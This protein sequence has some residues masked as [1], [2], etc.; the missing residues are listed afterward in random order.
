MT[1]ARRLILLLCVPLAALLGL[2]VFARVQLARIEARSRFVAEQEIPSL[3]A[4]GNISRNFADLR[5]TL[6]D[7]ALATTDEQRRQIRTTFERD[8]AEVSRLLTMYADN[9]ISDDKDRRMCSEYRDLSREYIAR[10][11]QALALTEAGR[12]DDATALIA[13]EMKSLGERLNKAA[14]EWIRYNQ[15]IAEAAGK[16]AV[17]TIGDS[18]WKMMLANGSAVLLTAILGYL[19]FRRIVRPIQALEVSVKTIAAGDYAKQV[20]CTEAVDE[21]GGLARSINVL[22]QGAAAM[23]AQRW[24][25]SSAA[26]ITGDLQGAGSYAE[27][28]WRF[29]SGL[30]PLLG[31]GVGGFFVMGENC[32]QLRRLARYGLAEAEDAIIEVAV[33]EGLVGQCAHERKPVSLTNV[34]AGYLRIASGLGGAAPTRVVA[35]PL[36]SKDSLLGVVEFASF[37]S[38]NPQEQ[39]LLDELIPVVALSLEVLQRNLRTQELLTQTREQA[40]QLEEQTDELKQSQEELLAQ[41][42]ELLAQQNAL[43][44]QRE[45]LRTSEERT[46][47]ILESTAE[48]IFGVDTK[49]T[50]DF[51][52]EAACRLLGFSAGEMIGQ[53]SHALIH[54]HHPDGAVYPK[55]QCPMFAAYTRGEASRIDNEYLWRKDGA[56]LPV[57]YGATPIHKDRTI[58][59]AVISFTDITARKRAEAELAYRLAFQ[60]ALIETIP[61]PMFVKDSQARF[62]SCN[63]AYEREFGTTSAF[64]KDKTALELEYL[65]EAERRKFHA[66]DTAVIREAGRRSYELPIQYADGQTHITLYSVDG[67]RLNDGSPGGLIGLLVDIS[68]QK[69]VAEELREAKAKAEEATQMKSMFLAN[70]S[71]EIRTPMNAIIG[72][73]HLALKTPLNAKQRDY[74]SKVHNAGTSLL[75]VINDILDFSKIEAGK[76]DLETTDF[77]L[78]EVI[79]SVTTLT[80]QKAHEKGLEFLAHVSPGIPENLLGDPLR[81]GQILT[82]F[83][84]NAVKF[85]ERG[86]IHVDI[87]LVERTGD[88]VQLKFSVRDTGIGMTH[89]QSAKLFQ[90]FTQADMSTT[91][92]HGGTGLGLTIC[93]RLVELMGGRIWLESEP[94][95]GS[96]FFFTVWLSVGEAAGTRKRVPDRLAKLHALVVDD[97]P[98]A[99]EILQEP[100]VGVVGR[101]D[102]VA[103]GKEA[104]AAIKQSDASAPYDVIFMD[105]RMPGMDGLQASRH[106]RCDETLSRQPAIILVTAFGREEVREEAERMQLEGFL[107]KPVTK[108]MIVDTLVNVFSHTDEETSMAL[109]G[110]TSTSLQGARILLVEDNEINQQI[111]VEL[112]EG[113][114][115]SVKVANHGREA[116]EILSNGPAPTPFDMVLMDLQMPEMD[117]FQATAKLRADPRFATLPIIAMT[118]H[119]T[120]EERQHCLAAGMNDHVSKPIDPAML[121]ATVGRYFRSSPSKTAPVSQPAKGPTGGSASNDDIPAIG[122]LNTTDGLTRVA[123]NRK[124]YRKILRQFAEQQGPAPGQ[125]SDALAKGDFPLAERLA[126][127]VKGVAG[128]IGAKSV[129]SAADVLEKSIRDRAATESVESARLQLAEVLNP[130]VSELHAAFDE[131]PESPA[132]SHQEAPPDPAKVREAAAEMTRLLSE[133]DPAAAEFIETNAAALRSLFSGDEWTPFVKLVQGYAFTEAAAHWEHALKHLAPE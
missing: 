110:E 26:K 121:F 104:I 77:K 95:V 81:L 73:S 43:T 60:R 85:T 89:E 36:L 9:L 116:V 123:G 71:H 40:R 58:V 3:A 52:N 14:A 122:G 64:L 72:L 15:E 101:V 79:T 47:L 18:R 39:A 88:K 10:A 127:T 25:K 12:R 53:P 22:K 49:G 44:E 120:V 129:Q 133:F 93:R 28:G 108:S 32:Q 115:A 83:V 21:T 86:E 41:K 65:P 34:P 132:P 50:I 66:E 38:F 59:G 5:L 46:R 37:R 48:G 13:G 31:G 107:V 76:L 100:L 111:A 118:A 117:G 55:E 62:V 8:E 19:T 96:T 91:R 67:F 68:D 75:A 87:A 106:I 16:M 74:V 61:Y 24:V 92:K 23:D 33:G 119:A 103:S 109:A 45:Q 11:K 17:T 124:L 131:A 57:E 20:P 105:W 99:R 98:A 112:L 2:A 82:N 90:P 78:D 7:D 29:L 69:R 84:N 27:F 63:K 130:L 51:V 113:A 56:G 42:E 1:I 114:G 35:L 30:V 4:L 97:N 126:H 54:H 94:G 102:T 70:M 125:I 128:N 6:R 80:A